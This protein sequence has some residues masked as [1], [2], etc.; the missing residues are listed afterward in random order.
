MSHGKYANVKIKM[1]WITVSGCKAEYFA[2]CLYSEKGQLAACCLPHHHTPTLWRGPSSQH[3]RSWVMDRRKAISLP[4]T[5]T[6]HEVSLWSDSSPKMQAHC[7]GNKKITIGFC[8]FSKMVSQ[9]RPSSQFQLCS[10]NSQLCDDVGPN[11]FP[12]IA[13]QVGF[14]SS[15]FP[16]IFP[17]L[18]RRSWYPEEGRE[19]AE[20]KIEL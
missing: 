9:K 1:K 8:A 15:S 3:L 14:S 20:Y 16:N 19:R 7:H 17:S 6:F 18:H 2:L 11:P 10:T 13:N 4:T 12:F 5:S